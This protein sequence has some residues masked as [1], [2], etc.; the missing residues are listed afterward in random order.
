MDASIKQLASECGI[1]EENLLIRV[2]K[3]YEK[4]ASGQFR[5][6]SIRQK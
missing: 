2:F 6:S 5:K 4:Y 3:R 1:G